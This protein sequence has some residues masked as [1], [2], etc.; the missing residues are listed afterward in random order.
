M[1]CLPSADCVCS[2]CLFLLASRIGFS[3]WVFLLMWLRQMGGKTEIRG[4]GCNPVGLCLWYHELVKRH[5]WIW[6][7]KCLKYVALTL[8]LGSCSSVWTK[9]WSYF[10]HDHIYLTDTPTGQIFILWTPPK[11]K[12]QTTILKMHPKPPRKV[13]L[14]KCSPELNTTLQGSD[15]LIC[16]GGFQA[17]KK[18]PPAFIYIIIFK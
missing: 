9:R 3:Y 1:C 12:L 18:Y 13:H 11:M 15:E 6:S 4:I 10:S 14:S 7:A 8:R 2:S 5:D 17:R 16:D